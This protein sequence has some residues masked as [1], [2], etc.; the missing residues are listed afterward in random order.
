M[1]RLLI[2][3]AVVAVLAFIISKNFNQETEALPTAVIGEQATASAT[4]HAAV[5]NMA[6]QAEAKA[7]QA[8]SIAATDT[9]A[10][11]EKNQ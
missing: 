9:V 8:A 1:R 2:I 5:T 3:A 6:L 7:K 10:E 11:Y 4:Q